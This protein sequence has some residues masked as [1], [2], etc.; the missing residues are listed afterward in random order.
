MPGQYYQSETGLNY[1]YARDYDPLTGKYVESDLIGLWGGIN[2][3]AYVEGNPASNIDP[4]GLANLNFFNPASDPQSRLWWNV[5]QNW[6]PSDVYSVGGHG[7]TDEQGNSTDYML[8]PNGDLIDPPTLA[9]II[10]KD[11]AWKRRPVKIRGC[12]LGQNGSTSFAQQLANILGVNV[13]AGT[14]FE[15]LS[16]WFI[17]YLNIDLTTLTFPLGGQEQTFIPAK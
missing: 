12:S 10:R 2:T 14:G 15:E 16:G 1:N 17:P 7:T 4:L 13:T 8:F 3:Y 5:T 11:R 9:D 6:N